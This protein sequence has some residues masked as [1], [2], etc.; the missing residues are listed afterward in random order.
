MYPVQV[1]LGGDCIETLKL[2]YKS[3]RHYIIVIGFD[4]RVAHVHNVF[5]A[6]KKPIDQCKYISAFLFTLLGLELL[7]KLLMF[8]ILVCFSY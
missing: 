5:P 4:N 1:N 8:D 3:Y 6:L 7:G 2:Y